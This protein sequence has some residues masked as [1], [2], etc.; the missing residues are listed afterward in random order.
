MKAKKGEEIVEKGAHGSVF[1]IECRTNCICIPVDLDKI[2]INF[3]IS[4]GHSDGR[5]LE[6][7]GLNFENSSASKTLCNTHF[8]HVLQ[9]SRHSYVKINIDA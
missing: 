7:F 5:A 3:E 6:V 1:C 2:E 4:F 8:W 9:S